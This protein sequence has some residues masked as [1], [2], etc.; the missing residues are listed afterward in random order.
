MVN[1]DTTPEKDATLKTAFSQGTPMKLT[2]LQSEILR[3]LQ[4]RGPCTQEDLAVLLRDYRTDEIFR[5]L[6]ALRRNGLLVP[7]YLSE[8]DQQAAVVKR[9]NPGR[10]EAEGQAWNTSTNIIHTPDAKIR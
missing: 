9:P 4:E 7:W 2:G 6:R 1:A 10:H 3:L 5:A 8:S